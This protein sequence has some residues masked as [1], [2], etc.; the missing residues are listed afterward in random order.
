MRGPRTLRFKTRNGDRGNDNGDDDDDD[1]DDGD[2][3]EDR[4]NLRSHHRDATLLSS[5]PRSVTPSG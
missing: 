4:H 5:S 1:N 2:E 3:A